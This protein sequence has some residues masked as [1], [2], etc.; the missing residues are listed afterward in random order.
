LPPQQLLPLLPFDI[1]GHLPPAQQVILPF[2]SF[3]IIAQALPS[4][5]W[6]QL[7]PLQQDASLAQAAPSLPQHAIFPSV[8]S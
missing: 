7:P 1:I 6:Q 3:D 8:W 4:L 2:W 5:P